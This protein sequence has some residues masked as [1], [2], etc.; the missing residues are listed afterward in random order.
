MLLSFWWNAAFLFSPPPP[1]VALSSLYASDWGI[2][3]LSQTKDNFGWFPVRQC[4]M[5]LSW[6]SA[7]RQPFVWLVRAVEV[8]L[9]S[10]SS[11]LF[12]WPCV[13][14]MGL[15]LLWC[16]LVI[17]P[18]YPVAKGL[19]C[20]VNCVF[21]TISHL[22]YRACLCTDG[23]LQHCEE[24][25][26]LLCCIKEVLERVFMILQE[27]VEMIRMAYLFQLSWSQSSN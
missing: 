21:D 6:G 20:S 1:S 17:Y 13:N 9:P 18:R 4:R 11:S 2:W 15:Q 16:D 19:T 12:M 22:F 23:R 27:A 7:A 10:F 25:W 5:I 24:Q 14:E 26:L 8:R 3:M